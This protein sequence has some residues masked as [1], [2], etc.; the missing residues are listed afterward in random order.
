M[1]THAS[2]ESGLEELRR[3]S[4]E[5]GNKGKELA[6]GLGR[7]RKSIEQVEKKRALWSIIRE[8]KISVVLDKLMPLAEPEIINE[9][10]SLKKDRSTAGLR[11]IILNMVEELDTIINDDDKVNIDIP[12]IKKKLTILSILMELIFV[13]E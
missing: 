4:R 12:A 1:V 13:I 10:I 8:L 6:S 7:A 3:L 2:E 9:V 5:I 11:R